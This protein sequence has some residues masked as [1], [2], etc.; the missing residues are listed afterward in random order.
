MKPQVRMLEC[1]QKD[2]YIDAHADTNHE[3]VLLVMADR[4]VRLTRTEANHIANKL[5]PDRRI[6]R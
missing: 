4:F 6:T 5:S 1:A 2:I 3:T